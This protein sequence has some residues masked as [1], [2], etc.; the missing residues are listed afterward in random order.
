MNENE[1][2][3]QKFKEN[4]VKYNEIFKQS[5]EQMKEE[6]TK[7]I[8]NSKEIDII[9]GNIF[10]CK[11]NLLYWIHQDIPPF[12]CIFSTIVHYHLQIFGIFANIVAFWSCLLSWESL[13]RNLFACFFW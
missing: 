4:Q 3:T 6:I 2:I 1:I 12:F 7:L 9:K 11:N 10:M 13:L 5:I 8:R